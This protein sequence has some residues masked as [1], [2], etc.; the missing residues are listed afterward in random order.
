[1]FYN[2]IC[3]LVSKANTADMLRKPKRKATDIYLGEILPF[4]FS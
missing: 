3:V 4:P 2:F 1:M